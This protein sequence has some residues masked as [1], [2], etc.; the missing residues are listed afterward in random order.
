MS[1]RFIFLVLIALTFCAGSAHAE[2][3]TKPSWEDLTRTLIRFS[4]LKLTDQ[5]LVDEY[6]IVTECDLYQAFYHDDFKWKRVRDA[7]LQSVRNNVATY[8]LNYRYDGTVQIDR[9]D[10]DKKIFLF[11]KKS[12]I[13][14]INAFALYSVVGTG[15]GTADVKT[16]PRSFRAVLQ[17]PVTIDG[18]PLSETDGKALL[19]QMDDGGNTSRIIHAR[20]NIRITRIEPLIK[21]VDNTGTHFGQAGVPGIGSVTMDARLDSIDFYS[22]EERTQLIYHYQ[23]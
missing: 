5:S 18:L 15:C 13:H 14:N 9:Y 8:P 19:K 20:F 10:F 2:E 1:L 23:P 7:V 4:A 12:T 22:D 16:L 3:Y 17:R 11:T 6:S 21:I